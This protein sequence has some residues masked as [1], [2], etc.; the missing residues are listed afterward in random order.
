MERA[1]ALHAGPEHAMLEGP[2]PLHLDARLR[3]QDLAEARL[4][5]AELQDR[6][7][8]HRLVGAVQ[9]REREVQLLLR[10]KPC[11]GSACVSGCRFRQRAHALVAALRFQCGYVGTSVAT[12]VHLC[13]HLNC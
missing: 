6:A 9:D 8:Q 12:S 13:L 3:A 5:R 10:D 2:E 7:L 1:A 4:D 11:E